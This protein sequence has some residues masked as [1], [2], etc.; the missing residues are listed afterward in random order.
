ML[1]SDGP[2]PGTDRVKKKR[3]PKNNW[4]P[5]DAIRLFFAM[6]V[7]AVAILSG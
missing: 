4:P 2:V 5:A 1:V 3:K 7:R 6:L